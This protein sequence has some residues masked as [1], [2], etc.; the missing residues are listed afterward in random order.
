M[1]KTQA[2]NM[3][4]N[5][6]ADDP[7]AKVDEHRRQNGIFSK[8]RM[9]ADDIVGKHA[10]AI[11]LLHAQGR[12]KEDAILFIEMEEGELLHK[13]GTLS[14]AINSIIPKWR[15]GP[16]GAGANSNGPDRADTGTANGPFHDD[17]TAGGQKW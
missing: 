4:G 6:N 14:K 5:G 13:P 17:R 12:S 8:R 10:L 3:H 1:S 2:Q 7:G 9:K 11:R 16:D 15:E